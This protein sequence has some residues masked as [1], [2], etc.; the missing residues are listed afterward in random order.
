MPS[1]LATSDDGSRQGQD[2]DHGFTS[3]AGSYQSS[4]GPLSL[5]GIKP[6]IR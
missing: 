6:D 4:I 1:N 3:V 5:F 2:G